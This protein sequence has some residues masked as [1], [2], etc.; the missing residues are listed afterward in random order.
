MPCTLIYELPQ[1]HVT[2]TLH[3][4]WRPR[5]FAER[6]QKDLI[7]H[8]SSSEQ[9][10]HRISVTGERLCIAGMHVSRSRMLCDQLGTVWSADNAAAQ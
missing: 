9:R 2:G 4:S 1:P 6:L 5:R 3:R 7:R 10:V 8:L